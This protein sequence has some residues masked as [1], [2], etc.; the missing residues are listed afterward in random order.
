MELYCIEDSITGIESV[1]SSHMVALLTSKELGTALPGLP[2]RH[3]LVS[4][5]GARYSKAESHKDHL[6]FTVSAPAQ[7]DGLPIAFTC[8]IIGN[9]I[10]FVDDGGTVSRYL[11]RIASDRAWKEP[12]C[13]IVLY[14]V[15]ELLIGGDARR[16]E[17]TE[18]RVEKLENGLLSGGVE[19]FNHRLMTLHKQLMIY[20][21]YYSQLGNAIQEL[22]ENEADLFSENELRF[23]H[24]CNQRVTRLRDECQILREYCLQVHE[25]FQAEIDL[26]QNKIMRVLTVV[27]TIFLPL[28]LLA[29]WYGMNF[30]YMPE[31]QWRYGYFAVIALGLAIAVLCLWIFKKKKYW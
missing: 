8:T 25:V 18:G 16:L 2:G 6:V 11:K 24:L 19:D 28:T 26:R 23:F 1:C 13:G 17:E 15:L 31:L 21:R 3:L 10:I 14:H 27:T 22:E 29:G 4:P 7:K 12:G 30:K 9:Q 20:Y 5:N